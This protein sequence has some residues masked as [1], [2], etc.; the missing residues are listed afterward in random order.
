[1]YWIFDE[2]EKVIAGGVQIQ[3]AFQFDEQKPA[4]TDQYRRV[5][6]FFKN[7]DRYSTAS[8]RIRTSN[9][10]LQAA[11]DIK[12]EKLE[13]LTN[14]DIQGKWKLAEISLAKYVDGKFEE[15]TVLPATLQS[16]GTVVQAI[17]S[18]ANI[19]SI[20]GYK[21]EDDVKTRLSKDSNAWISTE[22]EPVGGGERLTILKQIGREENR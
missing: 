10:K 13:I 3:H 9:L 5:D 11:V 1:M 17:V 22:Y 2:S 18:L 21:S 15:K 4:W 6:A 19:A 7:G 20:F 16:A 14:S 8:T 12:D